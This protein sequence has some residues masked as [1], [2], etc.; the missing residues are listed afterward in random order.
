MSTEQD[1]LDSVFA[2]LQQRKQADPAS[3]YVA[4]LLAAGPEKINRKILEEARET[5]DAALEDDRPH[6]VH[7]LC[8]LL[9]HSFVLAVARDVTLDDLRTELARRFGTSG[10]VEKANRTKPQP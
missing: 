7:E 5:C 9:F 4:S 8:D 6:L 2:V 3:S 10:L 1:I